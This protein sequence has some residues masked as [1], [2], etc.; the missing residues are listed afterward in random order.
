MTAVRYLF[1]LVLLFLFTVLFLSFRRKA[2]VRLHRW[3][4]RPRSLGFSRGRSGLPHCPI[5]LPASLPYCHKA[6]LTT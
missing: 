2:Q 6:L 4:E 1:Y 5:A 3:Q